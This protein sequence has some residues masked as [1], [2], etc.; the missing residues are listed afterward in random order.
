[1]KCVPLKFFPYDFYN[2]KNHG[3]S[4]LRGTYMT[5][6]LSPGSDFVHGL[7]V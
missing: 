1:M 4:W 3:S 2:I 6:L 7:T 5:G